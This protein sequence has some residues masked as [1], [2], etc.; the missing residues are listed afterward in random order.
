MWPVGI[1]VHA[2]PSLNAP[3]RVT[4]FM[5]FSI[6]QWSFMW[7][8]STELYSNRTKNVEN[9]E[10][11]YL[12]PSVNCGFKFTDFQ[13]TPNCSTA[14]SAI[15]TYRIASNLSRTVTTLENKL[16]E[17]PT[18]CFI[19]KA[20]SQRERQTDKGTDG[21]TDGQSPHI[22]RSF[23][24]RTEWLNLG[25][26]HRVRTCWYSDCQRHFI[27]RRL[28]SDLNNLHSHLKEVVRRGSH[29][30]HRQFNTHKSH[31]MPTLYLCVLCGS[32]NKQRL[33]PYTALTDWFV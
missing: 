33:F 3:S 10:N 32:Q 14:L 28:M 7:N 19:T 25:T 15:L 18:K 1:E 23:L 27:P 29:Y 12:R 5:K 8:S 20:M 9:R 30:M 6:T 2:S 22:R 24:I 26:V 13:E 4:N 16:H 17:N 21:W 31:V 11:F